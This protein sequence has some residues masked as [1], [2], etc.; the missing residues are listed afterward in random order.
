MRIGPEPGQDEPTRLRTEDVGEGLYL[1]LL[2]ECIRVLGDSGIA[3]AFGGGLASTVL[4]RERHTHDLD[5]FVRKEDAGRV[6]E[7]LARAGYETERTNEEWLYKAARRGMLIDVIFAATDGTTFDREME[8]HVRVVEYRGRRLPVPAP[9]DLLALKLPASAFSPAP[10]VDS[11]LVVMEVRSQPAVE[12]P[13]LNAFF[14]FV[15]SVFQF[16]RKQLGGTVTIS[17]SPHGPDCVVTVAD[18]ADKSYAEQ[19]SI[20]ERLA[21]HPE[22]ADDETASETEL[23][24]RLET[25]QAALAAAQATAAPPASST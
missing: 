8:E 16:R 4:G 9:E 3:H 14:R 10:K 13:D 6:L 7:H 15:E 11:A 1:E 18:D 17:A 5:V 21:P 25:D 22:P 23:Q 19:T 24:A 12:V 20:W 2:D